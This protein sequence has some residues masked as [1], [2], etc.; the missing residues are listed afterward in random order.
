MKN[1]LQKLKKNALDQQNV[2]VVEENLCSSLSGLEVPILTITDLTIP[3]T[4]KKCIIAMARI[5]P[6]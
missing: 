5:H 4:H 3:Q 1:H 6:G 2:S